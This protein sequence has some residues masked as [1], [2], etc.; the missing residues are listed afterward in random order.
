[1]AAMICVK[2][3]PGPVAAEAAQRTEGSALKVIRAQVGAAIDDVDTPAPGHCRPTV[4]LHDRYVV[5]RRGGVE[6]LWPITAR[7]AN[8]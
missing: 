7:G 3:P 1:M 2:R 4:N 5:I 6:A 8:N